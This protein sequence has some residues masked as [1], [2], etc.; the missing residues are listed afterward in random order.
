MMGLQPA[1]RFH[2]DI[3]GL[4]LNQNT[5]TGKWRKEIWAE[6]MGMVFQHA[7]E[8]LNLNG[9]VKD[10]FRGLPL[11]KR[12]DRKYLIDHLQLIFEDNPDE[13]FLDRPVAFLSGGQKQRLNLIRALILEP[14]ILI[15]D[16][17][18]NGLDFLTLQRILSLI[19]EQQEDGK[20][21]LLISHNEE[22]IDQIVPPERNYYLHWESL[23]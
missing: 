13:A 12:R 4:Q 8:A 17:P 15:L 18:F 9:K 16:E 6:K 23:P 14:E 20:S 11:K 2:L 10:I 3:S 5:L 19:Q 1:D 21:F 7:D 22:I